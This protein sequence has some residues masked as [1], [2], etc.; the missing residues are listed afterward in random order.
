[1][2]HRAHT[3]PSPRL[4]GPRGLAPAALTPALTLALALAAVVSA[5]CGGALKSRNATARCGKLETFQSRLGTVNENQFPLGAL[6]VVNP[7]TRTGF[8]FGIL[9][10]LTASD[11]E[12]SQSAGKFDDHFDGS[13]VIDT[14]ADVPST[15]KLELAAQIADKSTIELTNLRRRSLVDPVGVASARAIDSIRSTLQANPGSLVFIVS[16]LS[17]ADSAS[18]SIA[19]SSTASATT[20]VSIGD[21]KLSVKYSC[22]DMLQMAGHQTGLFIHTTPVRLTTSGALA[23][24]AAV[25]LS[26]SEVDLSE[27]P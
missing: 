11:W 8:S 25:T 12:D 15:V 1:M 3:T 4:P 17:Y 24:D 26:L 7:A 22:D 10:G 2:T 14:S 19:Q 27:A 5:G 21:F 23:V 9:P 6:L 20:T 18:V 16:A 13:V